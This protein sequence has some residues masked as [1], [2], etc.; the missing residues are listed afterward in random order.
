MGPVEHDVLKI[1]V[2]HPSEGIWN[3]S[4]KKEKSCLYTCGGCVPYDS[5]LISSLIERWRPETYC[6]HMRTGEAT[7]TLQD[8]EILFEMIV[9]I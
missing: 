6:F 9:N 2:Y 7:I 5:E 1:Q 4:L 3:D 8:V